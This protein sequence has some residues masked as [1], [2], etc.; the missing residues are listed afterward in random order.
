MDIVKNR[1]SEAFLLLQESSVYA[2][3]RTKEYSLHPKKCFHIPKFPPL[4]GRSCVIDPIFNLVVMK[5][6]LILFGWLVSQPTSSAFLSYQINT[7]YQPPISQR[8]SLITSQHQPQV[9]TRLTTNKSPSYALSSR[10][11][12]FFFNVA[13]FLLHISSET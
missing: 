7:S 8:F 11:D 9:L 12:S 4:C 5:E 3:F 2:C 10:A 1:T 6:H 13:H